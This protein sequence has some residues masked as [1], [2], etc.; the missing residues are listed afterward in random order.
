ML[1]VRH[2]DRVTILRGV[3][4]ELGLPVALQVVN[5]QVA[6]GRQRQAIAVR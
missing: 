2:P 3:E 6:C 5:P 1:A 4:G